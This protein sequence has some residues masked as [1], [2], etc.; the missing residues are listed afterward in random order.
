MPQFDPTREISNR[1][2]RKWLNYLYRSPEPN[3]SY[4]TRKDRESHIR[5]FARTLHEQGCN[6]QPGN[7]KPKHIDVALS[8]WTQSGIDRRSIENRLATLRWFASELGKANIVK[9]TNAE[10]L[11]PPPGKPNYID[12]ARKLDA[13]DLDKVRDPHTRV[14]W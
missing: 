6:P 3:T 13:G 10:Y 2:I 7:I 9:R 11:L 1:T 8:A 12:R 4:V 5:I 14:P